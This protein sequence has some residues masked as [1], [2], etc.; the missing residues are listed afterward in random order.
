LVDS[1]SRRTTPPGEN[2]RLSGQ[3]EGDAPELARARRTVELYEPHQE[4]QEIERARML[5][6]IDEHP[7]ALRRS[8][9][10][11]HL[12]AAALVLDHEC[13]RAL[14]T[15]H[16]KLGRWLQLGG[17]VDG[18]GDLAAAAL[19]EAVEESGIEEL[20]I[21][22]RPIDLDIH[23]IPARGDEPEHLHLD[24][25]FI[26]HAPAGAVE[27]VSAESIELGW[28]APEELDR[29]EVDESVTRLFRLAFSKNGESEGE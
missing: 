21:D 11:G 9:L 2:E 7:D 8:C 13:R 1:D 27:K 29:I 17:H 10:V 24:V 15:H 19:R 20:E 23:T 26:A 12:T 28:F 6:F 22:P 3:L 5:A 4:A 16:R 14:L 25:R 18:D